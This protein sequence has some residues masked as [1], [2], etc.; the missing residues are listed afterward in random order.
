MV[1]T[2]SGINE[3]FTNMKPNTDEKNNHNDSLE[4]YMA[5]ESI[6][7]FNDSGIESF[8]NYQKQNNQGKYDNL[9]Y[10]VREEQFEKPKKKGKKKRSNKNNSRQNYNYNYNNQPAPVSPR[11]P[12]QEPSSLLD[13]NMELSSDEEELEDNNV[14]VNN[15]SNENSELKKQM[16]ELDTKLNLLINNL[17]KQTKEEEKKEEKS[18][19]DVENGNIYDII[20]FVIF[21]LFILLLLESLTKLI[22]KNIIKYEPSH[23]IKAVMD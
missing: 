2:F 14:N 5:K 7:N 18:K 11:L 17:N 19:I 13:N 16:N 3:A 10:V 6:S 12:S 23:N 22:S 4:H 15:L 1:L 9:A 21:G 8:S 20:L